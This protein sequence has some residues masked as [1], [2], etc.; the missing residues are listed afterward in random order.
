MNKNK[1]SLLFIL[2]DCNYPSGA[3]QITANQVE[4][5][6]HEYTISIFSLAKPDEQTKRIFAGATFINCP[7]LEKYACLNHSFATVML[8]KGFGLR[9]KYL[10][11]RQAI[12]IILGSANQYETKLFRP[13]LSGIFKAYDAVITV[14]EASKF[15]RIVAEL[16]A[17]IKIQWV[18]TNYSHWRSTSKWARQVTKEDKKIYKKY[19]HIVLL[20]EECKRDF[21]SV[22]PELA[23]KTLAIKNYINVDAIKQKASQ[24][25]ILELDT[26]Y[27]NIVTIGRLEQ[28]KNLFSILE[29][30]ELLS[31]ENRTFK[32]YI[33][34]DGSLYHSLAES[35]KEKRITDRVILLGNVENPLPVLKQADLFVLPS[36]YEG[37][38]VTIIETLL[39][40]VPVIATNVGGIPEQLE[41]G[42][43][44]QL[45]QPAKQEIYIAVKNALTKENNTLQELK[46]KA[47]TYEYQ[48][49]FLEKLHEIL[50]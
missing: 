3:R 8:G 34:G 50:K 38:P 4:A 26:T 32:W 37:T 41:N 45:V 42:K 27:T 5:L 47:S 21:I 17:P 49:D 9:D 23:S 25:P 18:H 15:R 28:E 31:N 16:S 35:I 43:W 1:K 44:G 11:L 13:F 33:I 39:C 24:K 6:M 40:G 30:A 29:I 2:D 14:S 48:N 46:H 36:L 12:S 10:K 7:E 20:N 22:Y 19:N